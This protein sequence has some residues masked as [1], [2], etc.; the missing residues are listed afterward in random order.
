MSAKQALG[1]IANDVGAC[2]TVSPSDAE[3]FALQFLTLKSA[4]VEFSLPTKERIII[5]KN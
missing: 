2:R 5:A 1:E 3:N 4:M